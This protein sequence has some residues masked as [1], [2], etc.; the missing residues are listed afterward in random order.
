M[1]TGGTWRN[2]LPKQKTAD[3]TI[4]AKLLQQGKARIP[5]KANANEIKTRQSSSI[6]ND[7]SSDTKTE[8]E[9]SCY[10]DDPSISISLEVDCGGQSCSSESYKFECQKIHEDSQIT[11]TVEID[12]KSNLI[13]DQEDPKDNRLTKTAEIDAKLHLIEDQKD[14]KDN[15]LIK[16]AEIDAKPHLI[17]DQKDAKDNQ[18]TKTAEIDAKSN[19]IDGQKDAK[20]DQLTKTVEIDKKSHLIEDQDHQ[21]VPAPPQTP[22]PAKMF[23]RYF[24]NIN[25]LCHV[26]SNNVEF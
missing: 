10:L 20:D 5:T 1:S 3:K 13:E 7:S 17:E 12:A 16:T 8:Y 11:E 18:L 23:S 24:I 21:E 6:I 19:L 9:V 2:S 4:S 22:K 25:E 14:A 15:Q 26:I